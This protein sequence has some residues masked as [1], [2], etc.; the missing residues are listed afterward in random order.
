MI[1]AIYPSVAGG[2]IFAFI[3]LYIMDFVGKPKTVAGW[4]VIS[5][6]FVLLAQT[7]WL[8][9]FW[10][11][12]YPQ[13]TW[14]QSTNIF[15]NYPIFLWMLAV[16]LPPLIGFGLFLTTGIFAAKASLKK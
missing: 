13:I 15:M 3:G 16:V 6:S 11:N 14:Y 4:A 2:I 1:G 10:P 8:L 7:V 9:F 12:Y 5:Y